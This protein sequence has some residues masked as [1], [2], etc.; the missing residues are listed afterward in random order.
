[1]RLPRP[2]LSIL[3]FLTPHRLLS[4]LNIRSKMALGYLILAAFTIL[5]VAY[6]LVS[7]HRINNLNRDMLKVDVPVQ[8]A[9]VGMIDSLI[10]QES[11][12]KRYLLLRLKDTRFLFWS[13][14]AE[15]KGHLASLEGIPKASVYPLRKLEKMHN[16][17]GDFFLRELKLIQRNRLKEAKALSS[18]E[19]KPRLEKMLEILQVMSADAKAA[20]EDK[21]ARMSKISRTAF[22]NTSVFLTATLLAGVLAAFILTRHI[23]LSLSRLKAATERIAEGDFG[24]NPNVHTGDEIGELANAFV[25]MG[26]RIRKTEEMYLDLGCQTER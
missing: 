15:F 8:A 11:Y 14:A 22:V 13:R 21:T 4:W 19:L 23:S 10:A 1:M 16:Q 5:I 18:A 6:A 20:Q 24:Y 2:R 26:K 25:A 7:L 17:Y 9:V 12:E 3:D